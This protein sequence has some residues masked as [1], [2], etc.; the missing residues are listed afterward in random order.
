MRYFLNSTPSLKSGSV[1]SHMLPLFL[2]T[3]VAL[4]LWYPR[5]VSGLPYFYQEDEA[6]H[7]NRV[8]NMVKQGDF[9][10][11][12][13]H[14]PSLHFYLRMPAVAF[15]FL[16]EVREGRARSIN[17]LKT[18]S[19]TGIGGY[20]FS[21]S[22]PGV[23]KWVRLVSIACGVVVLWC[24]YTL[25]IMLGAKRTGATFAVVLTAFSTL[26]LDYVGEVGVD[27]VMGA[28]AIATTTV[29]VYVWQAK[30]WNWPG[31][32][33]CCIL[34]GLTISAKYNAF[35]I[36]AVPC[37]LALFS[38]NIIAFAVAPVVVIV[39][40]LVG[41]PYCLASLPL[42]LD[43]VAYEIWHYG[44]AGHE[45]HTV[46]P[47]VHHFVVYL[48]DM[49]FQGFGI[50]PVVVGSLGLLFGLTKRRKGGGLLLLFP[51]FYLTYMSTQKAHFLRN[52]IPIVPFFALGVIAVLTA[53]RKRFG[54]VIGASI[55]L[56]L[57]MVLLLEA[58]VYVS[59]ARTKL[60]QRPENRVEAAQWIETFRTDHPEVQWAIDEELQFTSGIMQTPT[61]GGVNMKSETALSLFSA[62]YDYA[63]LG[64][65]VPQEWLSDAAE[66]PAVVFK[67][68]LEEQRIVANPHIT[69]WDL[70][71]TVKNQTNIE[72]LLP[73]MPALPVLTVS[74]WPQQQHKA[75]SQESWHWIQS[76]YARWDV[77][78]GVGS[79]VRVQ[80]EA[81]SI[82]PH[83]KVI[84]NGEDCQLGNPGEWT[85]CD[86]EVP[87]LYGKQIVVE[88]TRVGTVAGSKDLRRLAVAIRSPQ[89]VA[90][91]ID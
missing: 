29:G 91:K 26:F 20:N 89:M 19:K 60:L 39:A 8:V 49:A 78:A 22:H 64:G 35:P 1:W 7:F 80:F 46:D 58:G 27:I 41:T 88:T 86:I 57:G 84:L 32:L 52:M 40:F 85:M 14:K 65:A 69:I 3:L 24:V 81:M 11:H 6:H 73:S 44:I 38:R 4:W 56:V 59:H 71:K 74:G 53:T 21:A 75:E 34:A 37:A 42:F 25:G 47:G 55:S 9:N 17:D 23:L 72:K 76:R 66:T 30:K 83:E 61:L 18:T 79:A 68:V 63:V 67:G 36:I 33:T 10:P 48:Q 12:Y 45:G 87:L 16:N 90:K 77:E 70:K 15:G 82:W 13:F 5:V 43:H 54:K 2:A 28:F 50:G 31:F 62:G 51:L